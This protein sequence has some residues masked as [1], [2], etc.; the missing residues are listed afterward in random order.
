MLKYKGYT[1]AFQE[2]PNEISLVINVSGCPHHCVNCHSQYLWDNDGAMPLY[3][4]LPSLIKQYLGMITCVCFMGGDWDADGLIPC[5][6]LIHK[7]YPNLKT[8]LYN[9]SDTPVHSLSYLHLLDYIKIGSYQIDKGGLNNP[10][11]NQRFYKI[12]DNIVKDIT[13]LFWKKHND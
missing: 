6:K 4:N 3:D 9:G 5:L 13:Y 10:E 7:Q 8:C 11:T 2:V 1:V 12:Q